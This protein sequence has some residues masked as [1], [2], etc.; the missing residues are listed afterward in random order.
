MCR[1]CKAGTKGQLIKIKEAE[2][3]AIKVMR[4][5]MTFKNGRVEKKRAE[6]DLIA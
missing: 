5:N 3:A 2:E 6:K 4:H 1:N